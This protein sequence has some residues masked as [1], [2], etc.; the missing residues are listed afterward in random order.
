VLKISGESYTDIDDLIL[1]GEKYL[2]G[3]AY[4]EKNYKYLKWKETVSR[5][6]QNILALGSSRILQFRENMFTSSFYNAGYTI[7]SIS[8]FLPFMNSIPKDNYP[9]I[10]IISLDQWMFNENWD[11]L[12]ENQNNLQWK[13]EF[14]KRASIITVINVW[15]DII[16]NKYG[17]STLFHNSDSVKR[18]GLN[19][20][21]NNKGFRNDGSMHYGDQ[22]TKLINKDSTA[23]DFNY[24]DTFQRI[25][26]GN[27]RFEYGSEIN[28]KAL[29]HLDSF[30]AFCK[31]NNIHVVGF[32][33][34]FANKVNE[35]ME[36]TEQY[37]Y[38]KDIY[39]GS[40]PI[41]Q[42]Y[43]YEL[44]NLTYLNT[45]GSD[46]TETLDGFH[47]G[48]VTYQKMLIYMV[49]NGSILKEYTDITRLIKD[50]NHKKNDYVVY[51]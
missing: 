4:D 37:G 29:Q 19:A 30:L 22:I 47:G 46:D 6:K 2:I 9:D 41:F 10:L 51:D 28:D 33:P 12:N 38:E 8:E 34:P 40:L 3:Y 42:K 26:G 11:A 48:E 5:V 24:Y 27:M 17:F 1:S 14:N 35:K 36:E 31:T 45:Y 20:I 43:G 50:L 21:V 15:T 39:P 32:L 23:N 49:E 13:Y 18:I 16:K 7:S 25:E 44:W